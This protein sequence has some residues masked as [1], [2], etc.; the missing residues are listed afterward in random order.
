MSPSKAE[1]KALTRVRDALED[2]HPGAD[3]LLIV[4]DTNGAQH[5][6]TFGRQHCAQHVRSNLLGYLQERVEE[7]SKTDGADPA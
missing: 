6:Y 2:L 1:K 4:Q 7:D 5:M 3:L